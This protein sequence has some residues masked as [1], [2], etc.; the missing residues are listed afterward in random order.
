MGWF[1]PVFATNSSYLKLLGCA[2]RET[3]SYFSIIMASDQLEAACATVFST[4]LTNVMEGVRERLTHLG[5][6]LIQYFFYGHSNINFSI[7]N[8]DTENG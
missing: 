2:K 4:S 5:E 8:S 7:D 6:G 1:G 3:L